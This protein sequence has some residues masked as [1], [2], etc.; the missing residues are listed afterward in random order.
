[1]RSLKSNAIA[2]VRRVGT[3]LQLLGMG[4]GQPNRLNS[5]QLAAARARENLKNAYTGEAEGLEKYIS[6]EMAGAVLVSD[7][8]FP[9]PDNIEM[10]AEAGIK[11]I[12]QPGGSI[13]DKSVI[14]KCNEL[15][16]GMVFTGLRHFKH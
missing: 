12:F 5:T 7:A 10:A 11:N 8:F 6:D 16:I 9:F 14:A 4:A 13:R 2:I 1:M 15:D 3:T